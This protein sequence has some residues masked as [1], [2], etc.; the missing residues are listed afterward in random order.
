MVTR[1]DLRTFRADKE[2]LVAAKEISSKAIEPLKP[3]EDIV[4]CLTL[5]AMPRSLLRRQAPLGG[6]TLGLDSYDKPLI[7]VL[8]M[9]YWKSREDGDRIIPVLRGARKQIE[10]EGSRRGQRV[11]YVYLSYTSDFQDPFTSYGEENKK[12]LQDV[13]RR[14]GPHGRLQKSVPG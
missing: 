8:L 10:D 1:F 11:P 14:H 5:N 3:L 7:S 4:L 13:S 2:A 6:N 9:M 12:S